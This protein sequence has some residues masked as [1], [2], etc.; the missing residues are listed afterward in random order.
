MNHF[1]IAVMAAGKGTRMKSETTAKVLHTL[2]GRS[3]IM[4][5]LHA[6]KA[7]GPEKTHVIVGHCAEDVQ[8]HVLQFPDQLPVDQIE[9]VEQKEQLGTGHAIMQLQPNLKDYQG[10][11]M[12][13]N[14]DIPLLKAETLQK[15]VDTHFKLGYIA[16]LLTT[17]V[18][19]PTG[20]GRIVRHNGQF[21]KITEHKE[22]TP[23]E[24][25]INEINTG[26]YIFSWPHLSQALDNLTNNN[27][28]GEYYLTDVIQQMVENRERIATVKVLN[29][30]EV[31]G[32]NS[33]K[34]LAD[35][36]TILREE[37]N[38]QWM[39]EGVTLR[40][41]ESI[42]IDCDVTLEADTEILP[43]CV[44]QG[45]TKIGAHC[46][47][48]PHTQIVNSQIGDY[49]EVAFSVIKDAQIASEVSVG[50]YAHIRPQTRID[51]KAKIG[52][53]VELKNTHL[54]AGAKASHLSYLG[55]AIIEEK[56]NI[57][58]GTITCNYDGAA[59][60]KTHLKANVFTGSNSTLI[61][62][63]TVEANAYIAAGSVIT[64]D[65]PAD[66]L[67]IGRG[68]QVN[69]EG[70]CLSKRPQK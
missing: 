67:G 37:I 39:L 36:E 48:G 1:S 57:G 3:M 12:I 68:R 41:P 14:G 63:L 26:V 44:L 40:N 22:A 56:C 13:L 42:L 18:E 28:K 45:N 35:A 31:L 69:K 58:A 46:V 43:G 10:H 38:Q 54:Q 64:E 9:W 65:I 25:A 49:T 30:R 4:H 21:M 66:S 50:P 62:P 27:A 59:K 53:F 15:L 8:H 52:N 11:L 32:V 2:A 20:Y 17:E 51:N 47:I 33:R 34:E 61:A 16:T 29:S 5:V 24:L 55:D 6:G 60:H 70:W 23:A 7:T 19:D